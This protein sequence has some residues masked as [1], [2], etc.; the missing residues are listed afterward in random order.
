MKRTQIRGYATCF[1]QSGI[2]DS[3]RIAGAGHLMVF[4]ESP[5]YFSA[6]KVIR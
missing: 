2:K 5:R 4:W 3:I 1:L 6:K